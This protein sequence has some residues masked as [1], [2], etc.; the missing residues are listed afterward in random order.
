MLVVLDGFRAV[1]DCGIRQARGETLPDLQILQ[2]ALGGET[3][4]VVVLTHAHLDHCGALP[5]LRRAFPKV[6]IVTTRATA[7]LVRILLHDAVKVMDSDRDDEIPLYSS[8]E[9]ELTLAAL[10][11]TSFDDPV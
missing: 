3:P 9:V 2:T 6:P 8:G 5:V 7:E 4:D 11:P 1:V 10:R